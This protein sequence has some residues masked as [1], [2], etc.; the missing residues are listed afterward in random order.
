MAAKLYL[1]P[2]LLADTPVSDVL[3]EKNI[4]LIKQ[5]KYFIVEDLRTARRF[6]KTVDKS[7]EIDDLTFFVLNEHTSAQDA[8]KLITPIKQGIDVGLMSDAGCP[9]VADPGADVVAL[10][11]ANNIQV[12]PLV[13]PSSI[14]MSVMA[15]GMNGQNFA[16]VGYLPIKPNEKQQKFKELERR[17]LQE[18][19]CQIFIEAPYRN[20]KLFESILQMCSP[21]L[22]LCI[23]SEI[24]CKNE[25]I[26]TL[27]ISAWKNLKPDINKKPVIFILGQ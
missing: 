25:F 1:L 12:V 3:P 26:K 22:R 16:F 21:N 14:L 19:Q 27:P 6:L 15:S 7:I 24:T 5:L 11:H 23:A 13:G 20:Q 2:S 8:S 10:A 4:Q 9:G 17:I 18:K